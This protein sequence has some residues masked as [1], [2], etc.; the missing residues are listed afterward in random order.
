VSWQRAELVSFDADFLGR[1]FSRLIAAPTGCLL[2]TAGVDRKGYGAISFHGKM[3]KAHRVAFF[4]E[5]GRWPAP[6]ALHA[7]DTPSC[8]RVGPGHI[9]EGTPADNTADMMS[10]ARNYTGVHKLGV[11]N[12]ASKLTPQ[13]VT[14]IRDFLRRREFGRH[15]VRACAGQFGISKGQIRNIANGAHWSWL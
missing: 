6:C 1:F 8:V 13:K 4:L 5:H 12:P 10:K 3:L 15:T 7:C 11:E 9:F 2:W 14:A